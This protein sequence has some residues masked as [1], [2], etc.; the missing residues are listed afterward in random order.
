MLFTAAFAALRASLHLADGSVVVIVVTAA[1]LCFG[2]GVLGL[3]ICTHLMY[4]SDFHFVMVMHFL[5]LSSSVSI[6]QLT[7]VL[8]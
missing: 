8:Y 5:C 3:H 2:C 7:Y 4:L 6:R 1:M